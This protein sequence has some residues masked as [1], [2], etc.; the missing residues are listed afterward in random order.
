MNHD[1]YNQAAT[2]GQSSPHGAPG[3]WCD[4]NDADAQQ[5]EFNLIPKGTQALV[6]M[7]IKPGGYDDVSRGWTGG[8]AT[9]SDETGAVFLSCEFVMLTGPFA[10]RK[11][12]SNVGLHSNKG[13]TWAQ[14]GRSFIKAVLNSSRNIH[15]DDGSPDAQRS[16]QIRSFGDLDGAEFAARIGI[17][18]DGQGEY[19]NIIR[20]VIEPDHK[21][22]AELMQAK[23]QRDGGTSGGSGGAPAMAS[24]ASASPASQSGASYTPRPGNAQSRPAWAQ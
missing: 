23:L 9:A 14:M 1:S 5:G 6:R 22:Y 3:A 13:P 2:Y 16:R 7:A 24:P 18:K 21:E 4:F 19:R 8:Y 12:W 15:P 11:I 20:L 10:K 17:E